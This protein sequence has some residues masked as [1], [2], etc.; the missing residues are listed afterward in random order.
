MLPEIM[1]LKIRFFSF[2]LL[3]LFFSCQTDSQKLSPDQISVQYFEYDFNAPAANIK[4]PK[5]L[6]E[7]SGIIFSN[8][9]KLLAIQ[10]EKGIVY[11]IALDNLEQI[12]KY[13][14]AEN[15][16]YEAI[17]I[18]NNDIYILSSNAVLYKSSVENLASKKLAT[19]IET[20]LD[21]AY[22]TEGIC[23]NPRNQTLL[24]A[25]KENVSKSERLIFSFD[26]KSNS[27]DKN[28]Y[29][30]I[31]YKEV[32]NFL[33]KKSKSDPF[34]EKYQSMLCGPNAELFFAPSDITVQKSSGDIYILSA[35]KY[36]FLMVLSADFK[37][38]NIIQLPDYI[39][40]AEGL[41]FDKDE[42]L[43]IS[44]EAVDKKSRIFRFDKKKT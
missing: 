40:Q 43:Y 16:D 13:I 30:S 38:K 2:L 1:V 24:I 23:F 20:G 6:K 27:I 5:K 12:Q 19:K 10:D 35:R 3:F 29:F 36:N 8:A 4:L 39:E 25:C 17:T 42:N 41:C 11:E 34:F 28:P 37:I 15:D 22:N 31:Q 26:L 33:K 9:D 18:A 32:L 21:P 44:S 14:F 7:I